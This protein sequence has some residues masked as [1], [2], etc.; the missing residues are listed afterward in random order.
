LNYHVTRFAFNVLASLN[1][2]ETY[3]LVEYCVELVLAELIVSVGIS[4]SECL[5]ELLFLQLDLFLA[6]QS[7]LEAFWL[8][9]SRRFDPS[10]GLRPF[11]S[12]MTGACRD[13]K[14]HL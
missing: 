9:K 10:V 13:V 6:L 4:E 8:F 2:I 7:F 11:Y 12:R 5:I 14:V 3:H 1:F